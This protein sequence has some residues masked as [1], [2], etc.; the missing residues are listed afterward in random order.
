MVPEP[1]ASG[2]ACRG[3]ELPCLHISFGTSLS[4]GILLISASLIPKGNV[5]WVKHHCD[6]TEAFSMVEE[7]KE[8]LHF[9]KARMKTWLKCLVAM[10]LAEHHSHLRTPSSLSQSPC[11]LCSALVPLFSQICSEE[12]PL[13]HVPLW[14]S[15]QT[16]CTTSLSCLTVPVLLTCGK[17]R[18]IFP[19]MMPVWCYPPYPMKCSHV[20]FETTA[21]L[22]LTRLHPAKW[23]PETPDG[24]PWPQLSLFP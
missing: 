1:K 5:R 8:L 13:C 7:N 3:A 4:M 16:V 15:S 20:P 10:F 14:Q 19:P 17:M 6:Y 18:W 2:T 24:K 12:S 11:S 21:E 23:A 9:S 22:L